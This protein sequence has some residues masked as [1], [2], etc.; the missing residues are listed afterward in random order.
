M[1]KQEKKEIIDSLVEKFSTFG[2]FYVVNGNGLTVAAVNELRRRCFNEKVVYNVYKNTLIKKALEQWDNQVNY[3]EFSKHVL[4]G[5]SGLFFVKEDFSLPAKIIKSFV[6]YHKV[7]NL[8][9]KGALVNGD[10]FIGANHLET[11]LKL[12][13][14]EELLGDIITLLKMPMLNVVTAIQ[15]GQ[16]QLMGVV[17]RLSDEER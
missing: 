12:K 17:K 4:K 8:K 5:F 6:K 2:N 7:Y 1:R 13:S 16:D 3:A 10:L 9:F 15:S 14:K 11:L